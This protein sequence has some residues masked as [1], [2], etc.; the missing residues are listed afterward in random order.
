LGYSRNRPLNEP[1]TDWEF[2]HPGR[3]ASLIA[4]GDPSAEGQL[5][6]GFHGIENGAWRWTEGAFR[7]TLHV[8]EAARKSG[9]VLTL[10]FVV[11]EVAL[12]KLGALTVR[13]NVGDLKLEPQSYTTQGRTEYR[14]EIPASALGPEAIDIDFSIDKHLGAPEYH[15]ELGVIALGAELAV[16][17]EERLR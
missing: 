14:R 2:V 1:Q 6:S 3:L 9:G 10:R 13:G 17:N 4:V 15:S 8:P 12:K 16:R 5:D 11:P 7:M